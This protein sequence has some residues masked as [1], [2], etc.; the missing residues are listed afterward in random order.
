MSA[1]EIAV[2]CG[3]HKHTIWKTLKKYK[4]PRRSSTEH[5]IGKKW[6]LEIRHKMSLSAIER[7]QRPE[8]KERQR[9]SHLGIKHSEETKKKLSL[10]MKG[11]ECP[12]S[13]GIPRPDEVRAKVSSSLKHR[14][15]DKEFKEKA[16]KAIMRNRAYLP[17]PDE[18]R[19]IALCEK[20]KLPFKYVGDGKIVIEGKIPDFIHTKNKKL[21]IE[22]YKG[23]VRSYE[24]KRIDI[25]SPL[26]FKILFLYKKYL[27]DE[28]WEGI[29]LRKIRLFIGD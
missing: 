21:L 18:K 12:W 8:Y 3:A 4:I 10:I 9:I 5:R 13:K 11:R 26:G 20:Y 24:Q 29:C 22:I 15:E 23:P 1:S 7:S 17:A 28:N 27:Q 2:L 19:I 16:I 25:F 14:Y 6:P